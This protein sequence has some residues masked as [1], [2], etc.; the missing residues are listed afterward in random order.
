MYDCHQHTLLCCGR[1][2]NVAEGFWCRVQRVWI[3]GHCLGHS[4]HWFLQN[5]TLRAVI[6]D[7][8]LAL[9]EKVA[10]WIHQWLGKKLRLLKTWVQSRSKAADISIEYPPMKLPESKPLAIVDW[11][12][13]S[14]LLPKP[15]L[16][17]A[18]LICFN[19]GVGKHGN[20]Y[21][22]NLLILLGRFLI[23][24]VGLTVYA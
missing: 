16:V 6:F 3:Q 22:V 19:C 24:F 23:S 15:M 10:K 1:M 11:I 13:S 8:D 20:F 12:S 21:I 2:V 18:F 5:V 9:W 4:Q 7:T 14:S 17:I